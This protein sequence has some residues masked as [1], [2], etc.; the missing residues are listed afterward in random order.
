VTVRLYAGPEATGTP[1]QTRTATRQPDGAWSLDADPALENGTYTARAEQADAAGNVTRTTTNRFSVIAPPTNSPPSVSIS[2][3]T[4]GTAYRRS[5]SVPITAT[6]SDADGIKEVRLYRDGAAYGAP[7]TTAPYTFTWSTTAE[8]GEHQFTAK[9]VDRADNVSESSD[10][11]RLRVNNAPAEVETAP[12]PSD[13]D[14]AD[15]SAVWLHPTDRSQTTIIGTNKLGGL[16]VYD[17]S[18]NQIQ[19]L[20]DSQPNNV[21]LRYN[22]PVEWASGETERMSL[23]ATSNRTLGGEG[24]RLYKVDPTT[25]VLRSAGARTLPT[26]TDVYGVC[27]YHSRTSGKYYAFTT[28]GSGKVEQWELRGTAGQ[29]DGTKVREFVVPK[30]L[31]SPDADATEG[32]VADD[33]HGALYVSEEDVGIWRYGAEPTDGTGRSSVDVVGSAGNLQADVEGLTIRYG[34]DGE[35]YLLAS[36]QGNNN[37][38]VYDR[39]AP[40]AYRTTFFIGTGRVDNVSDTDGI[41]VSNVNLGGAFSEGVFIAQDGANK[42]GTTTL[43]QNFKLVP[44]GRVARATSE[45]LSTDSS[46]DP[47]G[48]GR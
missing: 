16:A 21:D 19:Y 33:E 12:I 9:A 44:W 40:N 8:T 29:V 11:V 42:D 34:S 28:H 5:Q 32:C 4:S 2:S 25:G 46:F 24:I 1:V 7:D 39:K 38:V 23:V 20:A 43:R 10:Q 6:A 17:L 37:Y 22:F 18:G 27:M 35:G 48:I 30:T 13:S 3:P 47:D 41:D 36:S 15:D 31:A 26:G 14:A 45:A